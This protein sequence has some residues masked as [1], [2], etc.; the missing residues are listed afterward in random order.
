MHRT[1]IRNRRAASAGQVWSALGVEARYE[2]AYRLAARGIRPDLYSLP[3]Y[4][5]MTSLALRHDPLFEP[6]IILC[7]LEGEPGPWLSPGVPPVNLRAKMF[8]RVLLAWA[9][10]PD[11]K[12]TLRKRQLHSLRSRVLGATCMGMENQ[13]AVLTF[14]G[15]ERR[16]NEQL[17]YREFGLSCRHNAPLARQAFM[18]H[19]IVHL[20]DHL[21]AIMSARA[22]P[23]A[24]AYPIVARILHLA[25]FRQYPESAAAVKVRFHRHLYHA[26]RA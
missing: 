14:L 2:A 11:L 19:L 1:M 24:E 20:V 13:A 9:L 3:L 15:L 21:Q 26:H 6:A 18:T 12:R 23:H 10:K 16:E 22:K 5:F 8:H 7:I 17:D 4:S 25:S